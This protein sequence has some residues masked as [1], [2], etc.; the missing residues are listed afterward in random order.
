MKD[1][2]IVEPLLCFCIVFHGG[3]FHRFCFCSGSL[4]HSE[5]SFGVDTVALA[6]QIWKASEQE[7]LEASIEAAFEAIRSHRTDSHVVPSHCR[8]A[9][10]TINDSK[11]VSRQDIELVSAIVSFVFVFVCNFILCFLPYVDNF[12]SIGGF[13]PEFLL[14]SVLLLSRKLEL[15]KVPIKGTLV[16]YGVKSYIKLKLKQNM[17]RPFLLFVDWLVVLW[18]FFMGSI[19]IVIAH[20]AHMLTVSLIQAGTAKMEKP[21]VR[22]GGSPYYDKTNVKRGLW[23]PEED[24][25]I[26]AYLK[27]ESWCIISN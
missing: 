9:S 15:P 26:L 5:P 7:S 4:K 25:K 18:Q 13:I 11:N 23:T 10:A 8:S 24:T 19:S 1:K 22:M 6:E 14:G 17:D 27:L 2:V 20:G 21:L 3:F 12:A 16:Y